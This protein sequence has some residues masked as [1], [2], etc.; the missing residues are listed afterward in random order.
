MAQER[1]KRES[2]VIEFNFMSRCEI[3]RWRFH[4]CTLWSSQWHTRKTLQLLSPAALCGTTR[5]VFGSD[6]VGVA[7][8]ITTVG[9]LHSN[10]L[11]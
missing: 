8:K 11:S 2:I 9:S 5:L 4:L 7:T 6:D 1:E 3:H 10:R